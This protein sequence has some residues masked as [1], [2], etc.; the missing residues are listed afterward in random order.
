M[1]NHQAGGTKLSDLTQKDHRAFQE[2]DVL[3]GTVQCGFC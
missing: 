3:N 1:L 2:S